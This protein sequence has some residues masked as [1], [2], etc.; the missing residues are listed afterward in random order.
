MKFESLLEAYETNGYSRTLSEEV[1]QA[2]GPPERNFDTQIAKIVNIGE[3]EKDV[4]EAPVAGIQHAG[5]LYG[6]FGDQIVASEAFW[7]G[8]LA[9]S[10]LG[11]CCEGSTGVWAVRKRSKQILIERYRKGS[12]LWCSQL[13]SGLQ[14][15][16]CL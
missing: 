5:P 14:T 10:H 15:S 3:E 7:M 9:M 2:G 16:T 12:K 8:I 4:Y 1:K 11:P 13:S 6:D